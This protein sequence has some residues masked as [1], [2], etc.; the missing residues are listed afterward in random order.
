MFIFP[1]AAP[2]VPPPEAPP[3]APPPQPPTLAQQAALGQLSSNKPSP[4]G[5]GL[6]FPLIDAEGASEATPHASP[7]K[8]RTVS[9]TSTSSNLPGTLCDL[10]DSYITDQPV[11]RD[12]FGDKILLKKVSSARIL[13]FGKKI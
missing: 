7:A 13:N 3:S 11:I 12:A 10:K 8:K 9:E 6:D 5:L 2:P 4:P 1:L